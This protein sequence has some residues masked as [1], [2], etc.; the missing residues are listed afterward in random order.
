MADASVRPA[1]A[2]DAAGITRVQAAVWSRAYAGVLPS[3]ALREVASEQATATWSAA[4]ATPPSARHRVLVAV[5]GGAGDEAVVGFAAMGP[6]SDPD[7]DARHEVELHALCVD[8]ARAGEGHGSRL[9]NAAADVLGGLGVTAVHVW[10]SRADGKLAEF[11]GGAG[12]A[13]DGATRRLD[14]RGDGT[15]VVDQAR[16]STTLARS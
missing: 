7:L 5:T 3:D 2:A 10:L 1:T 15:V 12:W 13:A 6:V 4:C 8:P 11:L 16:W 9:V 14:L